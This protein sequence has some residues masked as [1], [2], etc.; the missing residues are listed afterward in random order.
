MVH[1]KK[2]DIFISYRRDTGAQYART[3]QLMLEKKYRVFLDYDELQDDIFSSKIE[4]AIRNSKVYIILLSKGAL[5]RCANEGDWL[6]KELELAIQT[7]KHII[8]VNPDSTFDGIP[9]D[10][11]AQIKE[12]IAN[13]QH[14]E[15]SFGQT[16]KPAVDMMIHYRIAPYIHRNTWLLWIVIAVLAITLTVIFSIWKTSQNALKNLKAEIT[17][18]EETIKW[19]DNISKKQ[20]LTIN[21]IFKQMKLIEGGN[22]IQGAIP[23]K[24]GTYNEFVETEFETPA[25]ET[26]VVSFY[27]SQFEVTIG[28]WNI[29]MN[30]TRSGDPQ[31][32]VSSITYD[33]ALL[34]TQTLTNLTTKPFRLP[35]ESEW[36]YAARGGKNKDDFMF[37]GS[38]DP[39]D[40]AWYASNSGEKLQ[41][42]LPKSCTFHDLFNMSGNVSEWCDTEFS[43]YDK[44]VYT[45]DERKLVVR[46]GNYLSN[47]YGIT[48]THREPALPDT[49]ISTLGFRIALTK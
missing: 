35:T 30:D 28:Q 13:I 15:I 20:L 49:S 24:D 23:L 5:N 9:E 34:F 18:N 46:G 7:H 31:L 37:A 17:F 27:I 42:D 29:I 41:A 22:F 33:E 1:N 4:A 8:P 16:L 43:P 12:A 39:D 10:I 36:E 32:P 19:D 2:Y 14:S 21:D 26:S 6:R 3:L 47:T 25:F 38:N 48:V 44:N 45:S 11:P 40:V